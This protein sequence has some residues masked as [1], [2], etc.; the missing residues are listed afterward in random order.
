M[1]FICSSPEPDDEQITCVTSGSNRTGDHAVTVW[2]GRAERHLQDTFY[3]Y[4]PDPNI[5]RAAPSKSFLRYVHVQR[6]LRKRYVSKYATVIK[7]GD[8]L[9]LV[10][11]GYMHILYMHIGSYSH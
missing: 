2:F 7:K 5:T 1:M 8:G 3:R 10:E 4:T 6:F 11:Y 9:V